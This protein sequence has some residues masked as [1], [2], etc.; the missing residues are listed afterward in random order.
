MGRQPH[1]ILTTTEEF[2]DHLTSDVAR[3]LIRLARS[4]RSD[5]VDTLVEIA[6]TSGLR[7]PRTAIQAVA[8]DQA[9]A[10]ARRLF[11]VSVAAAL[12]AVASAIAAIMQL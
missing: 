4:R 7:H 11:W 10:V 12:A 1:E 3:E 8:A 2:P 5:D 6:M 9:A